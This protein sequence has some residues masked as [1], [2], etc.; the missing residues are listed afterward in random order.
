M[1]T[2][3]QAQIS[4]MRVEMVNLRNTGEVHLDKKSDIQRL[5]DIEQIVLSSNKLLKQEV[6]PAIRILSLCSESEV[7]NKESTN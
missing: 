1:L 5:Q 2:Q 6:V 7:E 4:Q 3:V